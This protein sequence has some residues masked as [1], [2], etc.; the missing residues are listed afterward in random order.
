M[1]FCKV[2]GAGNDFILV[3]GS[4][5]F[6][7]EGSRFIERLCARHFG[8]GADGLLLLENS[9][10]A[11]VRMRIF[12]SDGKEASMCG[13]ALRCVVLYMGKEFLSIE[14]AAGVCYGKIVKEKIF[15]TFPPI[16][17]LGVFDFDGR[18]GVLI[19]SG[20]PHLLFFEEAPQDFEAVS[21]E[22]RLDPRLGKE[23]ANVS[24]VERDGDTLS[25]RTYERGVEKETLACGTAAAAA[26]FFIRKNDKKKSS[27]YTVFPRSKKV[28]FFS[29]DREDQMWM[30]GEAS[31]VFEGELCSQKAKV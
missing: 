2:E 23:G 17:E 31:I 20:V 19:D 11:D 16:K 24:F 22:Y 21:R 26:V 12:N 15:A 30:Q 14:T 9:D 27:R 18:E 28:L 25:I 13:N 4:G 10:R 29:F 6:D 8:V 3:E 7:C 1:K 5:Y